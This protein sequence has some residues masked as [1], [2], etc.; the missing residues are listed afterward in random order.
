[1]SLIEALI[2]LLIVGIMAAGGLAAAGHAAKVKT[3]GA[4]RIIGD[5]LAT[6]LL[7]EVI[8]K[9]SMRST[10]IAVDAADRASFV[11]VADYDGY[12]Q[13]PP[14]DSA[15]E[16]VEGESWEWRVTVDDCDSSGR[17]E[18]GGLLRKVTVHA[19]RDGAIK[20][21]MTTVIGEAFAGV[22]P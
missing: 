11:S 7:D 8:A 16:L 21:S 22:S 6:M 15:G 14:R 10:I 5:R 12:R 19:L 13:C 4:D 17:V 20:A 3:I 9:Q 18:S 2:S 1:M